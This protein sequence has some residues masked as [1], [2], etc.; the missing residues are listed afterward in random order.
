MF[1]NHL[2]F[3]LRLF[4]KDRFYTILNI[5]GLSLGITAGVLVLLVIQY[6]FSYDQNYANHD[7]IYRYSQTI[8]APGVEFDVATSASE[9]AEVLI[10]EFPEIESVVRLRFENRTLI[11]VDRG[12]E[13]Y[14]DFYED[15]VFRV[16]SSFFRI[17]DHEVVSGDLQTALSGKYKAVITKSTAVKFFGVDNPIGQ[18]LLL[19]DDQLYEITAVIADLPDNVHMKYEVLLSE[20]PA[21]NP[22]SEAQYSEAF[23]NPDVF[24]YILFREN[25]SSDVIYDRF[26][27]LYSKTY[28]LFGD[29]ID[30]EVIP[31]LEPLGE[32]HFYSTKGADFPQGDI[33]FSYALIA[34]G[35]MIIFLACIN[36]MNMATARASKRTTEIGIRKVLG[37]TRGKLFVSVLSE[38]F[39]L[40]IFALVIALGLSAFTIYYTSFND[41]LGKELTFNLLDNTLLIT[42]VLVVTLVVT[43]LSGIYPALYIPSIPVIDALKGSKGASSSGTLVRKS[44]IAFQFVISLIVVISTVIMGQQISFIQDKDL[45]IN[46]DNIMVIPFDEARSAERIKI[47]KE[48]LKSYPGIENITSGFHMPGMGLG[49]QVFKVE[50]GDG[51][52]QQAFKQLSVTENYLETFDIQIIAGRSFSADRKTDFY[53]SFI[54]NEAAVQK[55]GWDVQTAVG[56]TINYF[57]DTKPGQVVGVVKNFNYASL[58]NSIQP[59]IMVL[60]ESPGMALALKLD[61][62][63]LDQTIAHVEAS[64]NRLNPGFP[65]EYQFIDQAF[66]EEYQQDQAQFSLIRQLSVLSI[67]ISLLGL[68][69]LAAFTANQKM[70]EVGIRKVLGASVSQIITLFSKE[71]IKLIIVAFVIAVPV[72]NYLITEWLKNYA[73][74]TEISAWFFIIPALV[75]MMVALLTIGIQYWK[76]ANI[77]PKEVLKEA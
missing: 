75:I 61:E 72:S 18:L 31:L 20:I 36:Y 37:N 1:R 8:K 30:G 34:I 50:T 24:T 58:H 68:V 74:Q 62:K 27:D 43:L 46:K 32:I 12:N 44:L 22:N 41:I 67:I 7:R 33:R 55:L 45:G 29:Q 10:Q 25:A 48:E 14:D 38:A 66:E 21:R 65:F 11:K 4:L 53:Y 73:Y 52:Q 2:K 76:A 59:M 15:E 40:A 35:L 26:D 71:Y 69:G 77:N 42:G 47:L 19:P 64:W 49:D 9:L 63:N 23:W 16:D 5:L 70:R 13:R 56:K 17:F 6:D 60:M 3:A 39:L 54:V 57:H 28:Q 51:S